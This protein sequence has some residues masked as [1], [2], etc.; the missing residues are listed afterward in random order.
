MP[1]EED[2]D[3]DE[4]DLPDGE[5]EEDDYGNLNEPRQRL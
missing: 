2:Q 1:H 4:D 3:H 5:N